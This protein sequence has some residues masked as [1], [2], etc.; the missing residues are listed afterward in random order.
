MGAPPY[1]DVFLDRDDI[2][3]INKLVIERCSEIVGTTDTAELAWKNLSGGIT[4]HLK[5]VYRRQENKQESVNEHC[6][7]EGISERCVAQG[8][9]QQTNPQRKPSLKETATSKFVIVRI[10]G[11]N[12]EQL[13]DRPREHLV[14]DHMVQYNF[15]KK[16]YVRFQNGQ[17]EQW[18]NGGCPTPT[19][20]LAEDL[21]RKIAIRVATLHS[22]PIPST[23]QTDHMWPTL[24]KWFHRVCKDSEG[25]NDGS[26]SETISWTRIEQMMQTTQHVNNSY[27]A[28][29]VMSH[30]DLL[31]GNVFIKEDGTIDFI[32][33]EYCWP[34]HRGFDLGNHF[35]ECAGF[36]CE[37]DLFPSKEQQIHFIEIY[38]R[39]V[40][41]PGNASVEEVFEEAQGF[42]LTSHIF[43]G[44]WAQVQSQIS[45]IDFKFQ[46]YAF[47]RLSALFL[48]QF[49]KIVDTFNEKNLRV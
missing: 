26:G 45:K 9:S 8:D 29:V 44:L 42:I 15:G 7:N 36:D 4:N 33:Y 19:A 3:G 1:T 10:Y 35:C 38:L 18:L 30:N 46:E 2:D 40:D 6:N 39:T 37:W 11:Q 20:M 12:S 16:V 34:N 49:T 24:W 22:V 32:D 21:S 48:P 47:Q 17:V 14:T 13:I 41:A 25:V 23:L 31:A 28:P 27:Q 43:W 5:K